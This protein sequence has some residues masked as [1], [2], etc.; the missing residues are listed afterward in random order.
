MA[1]NFK[2]F[3]VFYASD[4][5]DTD[6]S[7]FRSCY[8]PNAIDVVMIPISFHWRGNFCLVGNI[9]STLMYLEK[10]RRKKVLNLRRRFKYK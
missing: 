2:N 4:L 3:Y 6:N 1:T 7:I 5:L 10:K 9:T 8:S